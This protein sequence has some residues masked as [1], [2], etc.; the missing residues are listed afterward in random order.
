MNIVK[1]TFVLFLFILSIVEVRNPQIQNKQS[2]ES[3]QRWRPGTPR[4]KKNR[5]KNSLGTFCSMLVRVDIEK[6]WEIKN[7]GRL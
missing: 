6:S 7:L 5:A 4:Y 3:E 1:S 2:S